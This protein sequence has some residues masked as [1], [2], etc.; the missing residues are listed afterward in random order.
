MKYRVIDISSVW[1]FTNK[2]RGE[3]IPARFG[4]YYLCRLIRS[5]QGCAYTLTEFNDFVGFEFRIPLGFAVA[6]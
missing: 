4:E 6:E 5:R 3:G 1:F 2:G